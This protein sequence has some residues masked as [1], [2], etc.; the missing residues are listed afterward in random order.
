MPT[1]STVQVKW[2]SKNK[3]RTEEIKSPDLQCLL[4]SMVEYTQ[5]GQFQAA[6]LMSLNAE[7][8]RDMQICTLKP[9]KPIKE[10]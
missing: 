7:S 6:S 2:L 5:D 1:G 3:Q 9:I 4:T 8:G 10:V